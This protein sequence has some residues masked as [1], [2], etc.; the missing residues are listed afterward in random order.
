MYVSVDVCQVC[1]VTCCIF[2]IFRLWQMVHSLLDHRSMK[3]WTLTTLPPWSARPMGTLSLALFGHAKA[4]NVFSAARQTLKFQQSHNLTLE[5]TCVQLPWWDLMKSAGKFI[6][7]KMVNVIV[8]TKYT[9]FIQS[10]LNLAFI[11]NVETHT[12]PTLP[13]KC[14]GVVLILFH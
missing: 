2:V 7:Y 10:T 4:P 6:S 14:D 11:L 13:C 5:F 8:F 1:M 9:E 12:L 3:R